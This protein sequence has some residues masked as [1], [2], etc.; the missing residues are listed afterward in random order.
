MK[1]EEENLPTNPQKRLICDD[2]EAQ[3]TEPRKRRITIRKSQQHQETSSCEL[4]CKA[5]EVVLQH[6]MNPD[7]GWNTAVLQ[8]RLPSLNEDIVTSRLALLS[9]HVDKDSMRQKWADDLKK[10]QLRW[11]SD[12]ILRLKRE[13]SEINIESMLPTKPLS[14]RVSQN[15]ACL[16]LHLI[17]SMSMI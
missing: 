4:V 2:E 9:E 8:E 1:I 10:K 5:L 3:P 6:L 16:Y 15:K 13:I 17:L 7:L 14:D 12:D 11:N